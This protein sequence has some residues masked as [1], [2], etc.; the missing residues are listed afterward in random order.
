MTAPRYFPAIYATRP[1][2]PPTKPARSRHECPAGH[3]Y[4][5]PPPNDW[6]LRK[7]FDTGHA[8][9]TSETEDE[10]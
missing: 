6:G 4:T 3:T 1:S 2:P 5:G 10:G 7:W 9:H 8:G